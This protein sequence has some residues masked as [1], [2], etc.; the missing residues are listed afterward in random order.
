MLPTRVIAFDIWG[1]YACFRRGYTTTSPITYPVP[2]RTVLAGILSAILGKERDSYY[3]L[4]NNSE[5]LFGL[6]LLSPIRKIRIMQNLIDTK[7]GLNLQEARGQ[8]TQIPFEYVK[9]PHY[10]IFCW[11]SNMEDYDKLRELVSRHKS[12]YTPY[13]GISECL[14]NFGFF[15]EFLEVREKKAES[16]CVD[17]S[18]V[19]LGENFQIKIE[20]GKR[21]GKVRIPHTMNSKRVVTKFADIIYEENGNTIKITN[22][23]YYELINNNARINVVLF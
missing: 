16:D 8:R 19:I 2:P 12:V 7:Q 3:D 13:L 22:G 15:G 6:Q 21:Y 20:P 23:N 10:R 1:D 5:V 18:T 14:A 11:I 17:I 9:R 4:F